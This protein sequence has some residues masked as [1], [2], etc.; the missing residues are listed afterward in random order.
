[1][2]FLNTKQWTQSNQ[3]EKRPHS[4][5]EE[6]S[7]ILKKGPVY[8]VDVSTIISSMKHCVLWGRTLF[9]IELYFDKRIIHLLVC[10][11]VCVFFL[12]HWGLT[13]GT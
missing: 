7:L 2:V 11:F 5:D 12:N 9:C 3:I 6:E 10:F 4:P 8:P 13:H 1:M